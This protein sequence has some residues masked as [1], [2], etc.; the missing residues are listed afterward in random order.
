MANKFIPLDFEI[1]SIL[2]KEKF[3]LKKL[4]SDDAKKD[5]DAVMSSVD[6]IKG[7]FGNEWPPSDLTFDEE[8]MSIKLHQQD[9]DNRVSF[10]YTVLNSEQTKCL[11]CVYLYPSHKPE[12][13]AIVFLW[14]RQSEV[15]NGFDSYLFSMVK[16][17]IKE[18]W[19]FENVAYPGRDV[20]WDEFD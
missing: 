1:P 17:W 2:K 19:P 12:Y 15:A 9:M 16:E 10:A 5:Y 4:S 6:Y 11:G 20:S 14:V 13:D 7:V 18:K 3:L 8:L